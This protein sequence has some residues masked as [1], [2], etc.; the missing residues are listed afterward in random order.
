MAGPT[1]NAIS[2][3]EIVRLCRKLPPERTKYLTELEIIAIMG[4]MNDRSRIGRPGANEERRIASARRRI[5]PLQL[6]ASELGERRRN[7][8]RAR[9]SAQVLEK[10]Q[11]GQGNPRNAEPYSWIVLAR[12]WPD[13]AEFGFGLDRAWP[14][15]NTHSMESVHAN[16]RREPDS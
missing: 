8:F 10:A 15:F 9:G 13:L 2:A 14:N 7:Y 4:V 11:F 1:G 6:S 16:S 12:A 5:M 3:V